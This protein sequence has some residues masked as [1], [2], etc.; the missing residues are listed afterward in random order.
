MCRH[1]NARKEPYKKHRGNANALST[2]T[3]RTKPSG[4][5]LGI[6]EYDPRQLKPRQRRTRGIMCENVLQYKCSFATQ[7][8]STTLYLLYVCVASKEHRICI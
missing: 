5:T 2:F 7:T 1:S 6:K 8:L 4:G 3:A